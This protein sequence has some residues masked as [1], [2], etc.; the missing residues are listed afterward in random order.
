MN[1]PSCF[2]NLR[3][4]TKPFAIRTLLQFTT[5]KC[6]VQHVSDKE[7]KQPHNCSIPFC[8]VTHW[9]RVECYRIQR[10]PE[11]IRRPAKQLQEQFWWRKLSS[12]AAQY[13]GGRLT[14]PK[15]DQLPNAEVYP[16]VCRRIK[17]KLSY[18]F[19]N[20]FD[21]FFQVAPCLAG[22]LTNQEGD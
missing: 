16:N 7:M 5:H 19:I 21:F 20:D 15:S 17:L 18:I 8:S 12:S 2:H 4:E 9:Y 6:K 1:L 11:L 22:H 13:P 10:L 3:L 14:N